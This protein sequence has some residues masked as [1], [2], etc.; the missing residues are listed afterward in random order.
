MCGFGEPLNRNRELS[1]P[2]RTPMKLAWTIILTLFTLGLTF[3]ANASADLFPVAHVDRD[4]PAPER[5]ARIALVRSA[6]AGFSREERA[7]VLAIAWGESKLARYVLRDCRDKPPEASGDCDRGKART[8]WQLHDSA[9]RELRGVPVG[10]DESVRIGAE[11]ARKR[12]RYALWVCAGNV[13]QSFAQYGGRGCSKTTKSTREK[14]E[15]FRRLV[16]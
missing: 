2:E 14:L 13:E 9:C 15:W 6:V 10:S 16:K 7:A 4:E 3:V 11:C 8:Y 12:W 1:L 5:S